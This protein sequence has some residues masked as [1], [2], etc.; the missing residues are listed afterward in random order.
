M[1]E[2]YRSALRDERPRI[3][4]IITP[5]Q[6]TKFI[7]DHSTLKL[8]KLLDA[9][10]IGVPGEKR[11]QV[12]AVPDRPHEMAI[13]YDPHLRMGKLDTPLLRQ[14]RQIDPSM[15]FFRKEF[16][17]A[18]HV[19]Y[20]LGSCASDLVWRKALREMDSIGAGYADDDDDEH[21]DPAVRAARIQQ[22][23]KNTIK[24]WIFAMPNLDYTSRGYNVT[25]KLVK[26]IQI[27]R[28]CEPQGD[29]FRGIVFV[30]RRSVAHALLDI[31][32]VLGDY[33]GF[34][35]PQVITG[36]G[37]FTD[38]HVQQ[39]LLEDF[40]IGTTNLL[41]AT[42]FAEDIEIPSC[43]C[44]I[45]FNIFE[46]QV[47]YAYA[48]AR[49]RGR[50]SH[51]IHMAER[52]NDVHRRVLADIASMDKRMQRWVDSVVETP[53]SSAPPATLT[54]TPDPYRSDSD[55]EDDD[56]DV[57][58]KDPTT[59]GLI[60]SYNATTV[61]YRF[62][63]SLDDGNE[64]DSSSQPLFEFQQ[65]RGYGS[66]NMHI[67]T[68]I[69]PSRSPIRSISGPPYPT[70]SAARRA[71]CLQACE[72]LFHKGY[73]DHRLFP[74]PRPV[75]VRDKDD[76]DVPLVKQKSSGTR[77]YPRRK[78]DFWAN[79]KGVFNGQLYPTVIST[80]SKLED[81]NQS[82]QPIVILTRLPLPHID[83]FKIFFAG[84]PA[85][86]FF[87]SGAPFEVDEE[88]L[89]L[90][91]KYTLR[92]CRIV[93]NKP[94]ICKLEE[95]TYFFAPLS[96]SWIQEAMK[97]RAKWQFPNVSNHIPWDLVKAAAEEWVVALRRDSIEVLAEDI[98]DAVIQDRWV[99]FTRRYDAVRVRPDL[100]PLSKPEDSPREASY[101]NLVE[102]CKARRKG[103]EG[104][105]DYSQPLVEVS[106]VPAVTNL[107]NPSS[108]PFTSSKKNPAKY[109]IPELCCKSTVPASTMRMT[110]LLPSIIRRLDD[111]LL[112]KEL[113]AKFFDHSIR[114]DLLHTAISAPSAG[115]EFDYERL[116]LLGD[117]YLKYL[118]SIY[119][120]VTNP[121]LHEGALH[122]ARQRIIS[123]RSL[124]KNA[125]RS[126]LPQYIQ[127]KP[128]TSKAWQ[129]PN[130][131]V[132]RPPR[133]V[134]PDQVTEN[135]EPDTAEKG[136]EGISQLQDADDTQDTPAP[137]M[138][139]TAAVS[140]PDDMTTLTVGEETEKPSRP[141]NGTE[142]AP[143]NKPGRRA[144]KRHEDPNVQWLGD[145]GVADVAEA[146]IGAAYITAGRELA[147][148]V[149]KAMNIPVPHIDRWTDFARKTLA[150]PPEVSA[151]LKPG[152]VEH[153]ERA[154]GH[155]FKRPH[156]L[157]QALTHVS[158]QGHE[159]T[160][161]ERLE[162]IGDAIL[163]FLV[164][165]YIFNRDGQQSPGAL[166]LLKGAMVSNSTLAAVCVYSR[167]HEF[168]LYESELITNSINVYSELLEEARKKD[169]I[170][171][172]YEGRLPGQYWVD[173][174]Q[175]KVLS[176]VLESVMGAIYVSDN[177]S[178]EGVEAFFDNILRPFFDRHITLKTLSHHPTKILFEL[179]QS[180][181][182]Q[183]F[184]ISKSTDPQRP[185]VA[186][187]DVII[188][189]IILARGEDQTTQFAARKA[190]FFALD[191][192]D[193]DPDFMARYCSCRAQ[194]DAKKAAMKSIKNVEMFLEP[195]AEDADADADMEMRMVE[196]IA[197]GSV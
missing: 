69:L 49:T 120:F 68:V 85:N 82:Y 111:I 195:D 93:A 185:G 36:H 138:N 39:D 76:D 148:R 163:D 14:L 101:D 46:S 158:I 125:D 118:S 80:D 43:S 4:G 106:R 88:E 155:T 166:T 64:D 79:T 142:G 143:A 97:L 19:G 44:V 134:V 128:F 40:R 145:K 190:S 184:E 90:L 87:Q 119:L 132:F 137:T 139:K 59:S 51:L 153:I 10:M 147:L 13:F 31:L 110:L 174:E 193:G 197:L 91:H 56:A 37:P 170:Q 35:R 1:V 156:L 26:L 127:S 55:D 94:F 75:S 151:P 129:P 149:T 192:L 196:E 67:C 162:F 113:N 30:Q 109:L 173:I 130:F 108:R 194:N 123:N 29:S 92:I 6:D 178:P 102:Y 48:R 141:P 71:A 188:H 18:K 58:V 32:R 136:P 183:E 116:E 121:T 25:P 104:L 84:S 83:N 191:A 107:L 47:S 22:K 177:F 95:M 182:C 70:P 161:Y 140:K 187:C 24:N 157:A 154:I 86:V 73:L 77:S 117:A 186:I 168:L 171:A 33:V 57:F 189:D 11:E 152:T 16:K 3:L 2:M 159:T 114:E 112:V 103:F 126:G 66:R 164:I 62:A 23:V 61:I 124:L 100:S 160:S 96:S 12:M 65:L 54:E 17:D 175:P 115:V 131:R 27:L 133:P 21:T 60:Q 45:R 150:P 52:G 63:A 8:E 7:F 144:N 34:I 169:E 135:G 99:E 42:K 89:M 15:E 81:P 9:T 98:K 53:E 122:I 72:E 5:E 180:R 20:E 74:R 78:P 146:I 167:I 179:F 50:N 38:P 41:I 105:E 165:R 28:A 176:D 181:G 172:N